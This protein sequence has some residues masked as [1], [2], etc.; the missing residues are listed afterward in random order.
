LRIAPIAVTVT[1]EDFL[2]SG[3]NRTGRKRCAGPPTG[4]SSLQNWHYKIAHLA[5]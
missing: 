3:F 2:I 1:P 5:A 4:G